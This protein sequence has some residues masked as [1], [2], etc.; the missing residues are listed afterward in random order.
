MHDHLPK[1][2]DRTTQNLFSFATLFLDTC[3]NLVSTH[4]PQFWS[5]IALFILK[6]IFVIIT[7]LNGLLITAISLPV[8]V[9][10]ENLFFAL[11][12]SS[13]HPH[14]GYPP[15]HLPS[16]YPYVP[17][18]DPGVKAAPAHATDSSPQ[19][20]AI[21]HPTGTVVPPSARASFAFFFLMPQ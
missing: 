4:A 6:L 21:N 1:S 16:F 3:Q 18:L 7:L 19:S 14:N 8:R 2:T 15:I 10:N 17:R 5:K 12:P 13:P 9:A 20:W 11:N